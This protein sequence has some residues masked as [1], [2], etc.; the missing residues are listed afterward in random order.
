MKRNRRP[1]FIVLAAALATLVIAHSLG[2][3]AETAT[4]WSV[5]VNKIDPGDI[6]LAPSFQ[7]AIY[8]N[9]FDELSKTKQFKQVL[10]DGDRNAAD[11]PDLLILKTTIES[12][13]AGSETRRAVTTF[14]GATKLTVRT[15]LFTRDGKIILEHT[16]NGNVRFMGSNL[17][18][19]H[20]LARNVAKAIAKSSLPEPPSAALSEAMNSTS[21]EIVVVELP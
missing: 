20:N 19:T 9:I 6:K 7:I 12:Y 3:S 16:V 5:Q 4:R 17:R 15:Q 2:L 13:T 1:S 8:E 11:V 21:S 10:R 14:N 18:A